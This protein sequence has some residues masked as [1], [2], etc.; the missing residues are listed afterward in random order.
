MQQGQSAVWY[1]YTA[2]NQRIGPFTAKVLKQLV[3]I[4]QITPDTIIENV[5]GRREVAGKVRGLVFP[6][7]KSEPAVPHS[8]HTPTPISVPVPALTPQ[9]TAGGLWE[10]Y[11]DFVYSAFSIFGIRFGYDLNR[12]LRA[13]G[14]LRGL[15][16]QTIIAQVGNPNSVS[17]KLNAEGERITIRQW[18]ATGYHIALLFDENDVCLGVGHE[19]AAFVKSNK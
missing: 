6:T 12:K 3:A 17:T 16:A 14:T 9:K 13:L 4:G 2:D 11:V 10:R 18:I 15:T 1:Y 5:N 7:A 19:F 8:Q